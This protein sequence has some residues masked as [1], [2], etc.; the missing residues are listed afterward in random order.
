MAATEQPACSAIL[1]VVM[2]AASKPVSS[3]AVASM[4]D[5]T[6]ARLRSC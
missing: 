1:V 4:I 6:R 3:A 5:S 2:S